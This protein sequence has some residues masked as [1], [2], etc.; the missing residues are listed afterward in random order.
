MK[1]ETILRIIATIA[2]VA[3]FTAIVFAIQPTKVPIWGK[4]LALFVLC[5]IWGNKMF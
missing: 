5:G 3:G 1:T 2:V 4:A